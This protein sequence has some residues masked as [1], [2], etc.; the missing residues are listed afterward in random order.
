MESLKVTKEEIMEVAGY[1]PKEFPKYTVSVINLL[2]RWAGGTASK[3][4]GQM[5]D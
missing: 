5:S 1:K 2:N 4:V 3:I